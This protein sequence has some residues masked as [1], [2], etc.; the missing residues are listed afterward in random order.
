M[1]WVIARELDQ[2]PCLWLLIV[3]GGYQTQEY[4]KEYQVHGI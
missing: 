2:I 1:Y 4:E 3:A